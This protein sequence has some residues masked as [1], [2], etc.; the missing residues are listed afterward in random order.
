M[1]LFFGVA[2]FCLGAN[3]QQTRLDIVFPVLLHDKLLI[4]HQRQQMI[5]V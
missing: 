2:A 4:S 3:R 5:R 1:M